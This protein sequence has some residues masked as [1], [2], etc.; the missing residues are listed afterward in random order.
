MYVLGFV[1]FSAIATDNYFFGDCDILGVDFCFATG[2]SFQHMTHP[3]S[4]LLLFRDAAL[5]V[6]R[7]RKACFQELCNISVKSRRPLYGCRLR[8]SKGEP[9]RSET[10]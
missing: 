9:I 10:P 7:P 5:E 4:V 2:S 6:H 3:L 8:Q 1:A